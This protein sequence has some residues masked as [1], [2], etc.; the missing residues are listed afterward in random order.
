MSEE[1]K[2]IPREPLTERQVDDQINKD[3]A[4]KRAEEAAARERQEANHEQIERERNPGST[5]PDQN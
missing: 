2:E 3:L 1:K 4:R 5:K